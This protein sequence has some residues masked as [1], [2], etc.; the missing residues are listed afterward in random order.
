MMMKTLNTFLL[1]L[2][3]GVL[4]MVGLS[5][6]QEDNGPQEPEVIGVFMHADW[7]GGCQKLKPKLNAVKPQFK[8]RPVLFTGFDKT[9]DFTKEQSRMLAEQ[10]G[11]T[12]LYKDHKGRTAYV[13]LVDADTKEELDILK[14]KESEEQLKNSIALALNSR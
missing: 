7:C 9:D 12:Q 10:M 8:D 6:A 11:L 4:G 5:Q 3:I 1:A 14:Y 2:L 13:V